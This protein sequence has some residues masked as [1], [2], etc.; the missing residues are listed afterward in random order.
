MA[1]L[2]EFYQGKKVLV[3]GG[4]G[5][6]GKELVKQ[7][8]MLSPKEVRVLDHNETEVFYMM[9]RYRDDR[10]VN[11]FVG[12][13]RDRDKVDKV[14]SGVDVVIHCAAYKHVI[15]SERNPF[16]AVQTNIIGVENI[17]R[18]SIAHRVKRVLFTSSDKAVNPTN[19]M[20]ASKLLGEKIMTAANAM[21]M[22]DSPIFASTRFGNVIGSR[23]SVTPLFLKQI[24]KGGPVTLTDRRMTRFIMTMEQASKLVLESAVIARGGEVF[25]TKMPVVRIS[26]LAEVMVEICAPRYGYRPSDIAIVEIGAKPGEKLYEELMSEEEVGR[27][28]ETRDMFVI[29]PAFRAIYQSIEYD[30]E[31]IVS[32]SV[33]RP[34]ISRNEKP[35][36][37]EEIK[38]FFLSNKVIEKLEE[39]F[40]GGVA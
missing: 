33:S 37:K 18:A 2:V 3:T 1:E 17:I 22:D 10:R 39:E 26:D 11:A 15:L 25:V 38:E 5:S 24:R 13:V 9:E 31:D 29:L 7:L 8:L 35:L 14:V 21:R 4:V 27:A 32:R 20:G 34:Y 40:F 36:S 23:G 19:V 12:D 6:V 30:Y 28:L 16:D